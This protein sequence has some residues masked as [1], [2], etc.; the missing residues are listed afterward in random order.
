MPSSKYTT[1]AHSEEE[2]TEQEH[3]E[4]EEEQ[5]G[6]EA[7]EQ[8][9]QFFIRTGPHPS[10]K[11]SASRFN[12]YY[13]R[14]ASHGSNAV[15]LALN[16]PKFMYSEMDE[17][18]TDA[19]N[20]RNSSRSRQSSG[21]QSQARYSERHGHAFG[22][23][24]KGGKLIFKSWKS[25]DKGKEWRFHLKGL[26]EFGSQSEKRNREMWAPV[27]IVEKDTDDDEGGDGD[28]GFS[29]ALHKNGMEEVLVHKEVKGFIVCEWTLGYPQLFWLT[30]AFEEG[31]LPEFCQR[32][33]LIREDFEVEL[34]D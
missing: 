8:P 4:Q 28:D 31:K 10:T 7:E 12:S 5:E 25:K 32:V 22:G 26:K 1:S 17:S 29:F 21:T 11:S 19:P 23:D 30:D 18:S 33:L 3:S 15:I 14:H 20:S 34:V 2:D 16:P 13:L 24:V 9:Y 27:E 6:E